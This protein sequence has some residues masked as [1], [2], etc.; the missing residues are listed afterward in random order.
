VSGAAGGL[1]VSELPTPEEPLPDEAPHEDIHHEPQLRRY[2]STIGGFFYL[3]VLAATGIGI[4]ISWS[5]DWRWGVK[6]IGAALILAGLVRLVLRQRDAGMLAV[7]KRWIDVLMLVGGGA[8][9][10]FLSESIP[11]QPL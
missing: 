5:D 11:N 7:R 9:L 2:P 6:W 8:T 1:D 10:I 4:W 3:L